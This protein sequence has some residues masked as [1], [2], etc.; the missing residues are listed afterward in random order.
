MSVHVQGCLPMTEFLKCVR[1]CQDRL[2]SVYEI[3]LRERHYKE[4]ECPEADMPSVIFVEPY[5]AE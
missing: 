1:L 2:V 5:F 3:Y 4:Y